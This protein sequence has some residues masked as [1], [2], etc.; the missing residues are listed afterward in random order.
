MT[1]ATYGLALA[2]FLIVASF[3]LSVRLGSYRREKRKHRR[4]KL[5][6]V[7]DD[8]VYLVATGKL[9]RDDP[10]FLWFYEVINFFIRHTDPASLMNVVSA[11]YEA[12]RQQLDPAEQHRLAQIKEQ[13]RQQPPEVA[14]VIQD[15]YQTIFDILLQSSFLLR[16]TVA[17]RDTKLMRLLDSLTLATRQVF[18]PRQWSAYRYAQSYTHAAAVIGVLV[19][20]LTTSTVSDPQFGLPQ[21]PTAISR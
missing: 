6:K 16:L 3:V 20:G 14:H 11:L 1:Q 19:M 17:M 8:W 10:L 13:L 15:F 2:L 12:Q 21:S 5:F 9:Q 4:F 18:S 7:R